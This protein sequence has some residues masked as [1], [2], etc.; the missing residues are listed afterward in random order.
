M[1]EIGY[2]RII[3]LENEREEE[4]GERKRARE[5]G[6]EVG[7][8]EKG[9]VVSLNVLDVRVTCR[10]PLSRDSRRGR[11]AR[12][13]IIGHEDR[14]GGCLLSTACHISI[15]PDFSNPRAGRHGMLDNCSP[16]IYTCIANV[17]EIRLAVGC[18]RN[19]RFESLNDRR[20]ATS[21]PAAQGNRA[22][23]VRLSLPAWIFPIS[24]ALPFDPLLQTV[25][26]SLNLDLETLVERLKYFQF[27]FF[28]F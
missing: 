23:F 1:R 24:R 21:L 28:F 13:I 5:W 4:K 17:L 18:I 9:E 2:S 10:G 12:C 15:P 22:L 20:N 25:A 16:S 14:D 26:F 7:R 19:D 27:F 8:R 3:W 6:R 11:S